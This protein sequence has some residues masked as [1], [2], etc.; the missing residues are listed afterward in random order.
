ME[1]IFI[2]GYLI[3]KWVTRT[4]NILNRLELKF[5]RIIGIKGS[6]HTQTHSCKIAHVSISKWLGCFRIIDLG[7]RTRPSLFCHHQEKKPTDE[8]TDDWLTVSSSG[9]LCWIER[10]FAS[11][12]R[13]KCV[14]WIYR[15]PSWSIP[16]IYC[17][18]G[19]RQK[20]LEI[21]HNALCISYIMTKLSTF[22]PS[23]TPTG[24]PVSFFFV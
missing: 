21:K 22:S 2:F 1:I 10:F 9:E 17:C 8:L 16:I 15:K 14:P 18:A 4:T 24:L 3:G 19:D 23:K 11:I 13:P 12:S 20:R 7:G 5:E 6:K